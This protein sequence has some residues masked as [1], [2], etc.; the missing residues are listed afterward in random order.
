[1]E[2]MTVQERGQRTGSNGQGR[3]E[4]RAE[5]SQPPCGFRNKSRGR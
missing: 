1:M 2:L 4:E 3:H 5:E